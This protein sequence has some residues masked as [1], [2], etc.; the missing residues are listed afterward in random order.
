GR[1]PAI[2]IGSPFP[3]SMLT[4]KPWG[5]GDSRVVTVKISKPPLV[6]SVS[7]APPPQPSAAD[8]ITRRAIRA[9]QRRMAAHGDSPWWVVGPSGPLDAAG[10]ANAHTRNPTE[11]QTAIHR[12]LALPPPSS[13]N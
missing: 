4:K 6:G 11:D 2:A 8:T 12:A 10:F 5:A 7:P 1:F 13:P 9:L 3:Q